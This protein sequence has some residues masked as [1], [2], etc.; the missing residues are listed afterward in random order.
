MNAANST[1][2]AR[3]IAAPLAGVRVIEWSHS[4]PAAFCARVLRDLGAQVLKLEPPGTGDALRRIGPFAPDAPY[5]N[6]AALFAYLN[7]GK[8]SATLD[9][10]HPRCSGV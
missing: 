9:P 8:E 5:G 2:Q 10:S 4:M 1:L 7:H 6:D 3:A